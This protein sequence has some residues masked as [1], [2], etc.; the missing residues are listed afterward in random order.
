[1]RRVPLLLVATLSTTAG[2]ATFTVDTTSNSALTACTPAVADCSFSGAIAA[3]NATAIQDTI[4]FAIPP[5]DPG[6]DAGSGVCTITPAPGSSRSI[7]QPVVIDG[8]TQPGAVPNSNTPAQGGLNGV[9][10]IQL[11]GNNGGS[12]TSRLCGEI[13]RAHV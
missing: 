8:Y 13:G 12:I 7:T 10:K 5:G 2:A 11:D 6:C 1:M 9:L 3:A 4:A